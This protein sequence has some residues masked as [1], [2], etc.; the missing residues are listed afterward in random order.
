[1][2][3]RNNQPTALTVKESGMVN[4]IPDDITRKDRLIVL[5]L[6]FL[7]CLFIQLKFNNDTY[8]LINSGRYVLEHGIPHIEPFTLH[9]GLHFVM[10]QWLSA[11]V[12]ALIYDNLGSPFLFVFVAVIN[13]SIIYSVFRLC[14]RISEKNFLV[15][16]T[17][18]IAVSIPLKGFMVLRPFLFSILLFSFELNLIEAFVQPKLPSE[19]HTPAPDNN[20]KNIPAHAKTWCAIIK[21]GA[22]L[23][24]LPILSVFLINLHAA[25][26]PF[27]F[28]L[29]I[30]YFIDSFR[31]NLW[32]IK[33]EGYPRLPL[34]IAAVLSFATGWMNPYGFES[35]AYLFR[36]YGNA[37]V[38]TLIL[39]MQSTDFKTI[40]GMFV[41]IIYLFP[42]LIYCF[43]RK[44]ETRLRYAL[45]IIGTGYLGLSS[46]RSLS[47]F[48]VCGIPFLAYT[49]KSVQ[50]LKTPVAQP[51]FPWL[52]FLLTGILVVWLGI[53]FYI[54]AGKSEKEA[55]ILLPIQAVNYIKTHLDK[56][57]I[58]LY[59]GY[60]T[61]GYAEFK[62]LRPFI[63]ARAEVFYKSNNQKEDIADD[64][65]NVKLGKMHYRELIDRYKLTHFLVGK[66]DVPLYVYLSEDP[67]FE[68]L[69][70]DDDFKVFAFKTVVN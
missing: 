64:Y 10:Q 42:I 69:F 40:F 45:L 16:F 43:Y 23:L 3:F 26:W 31:F 33:G 4:T 35:M 51:R 62:G 36:S 54:R 41:F 32:G 18:A 8:W 14:M 67:N 17:I 2:I 49:L 63:D 22:I 50:I 34:V 48:V 39:E 61:G 12:F 56:E 65:F 46:V 30:P 21:K 24:G 59:T 68:L 57:S 11:T 20:E 52:R 53:S 5:L 1:M 9:H 27:F 15:S 7:P 28:V 66:N 44:G 38:S 60:E 6:M 25:M 19:R 70:T 55:E 47:L 58:R 29:L 13:A 37:Y